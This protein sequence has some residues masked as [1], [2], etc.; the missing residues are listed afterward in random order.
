MGHSLLGQ[1][2]SKVPSTDG[3]SI[4]GRFLRRVRE[5]LSAHC[6]NAPSVT[7]RALIERAA[8]LSL[9]VARFDVMALAAGGLSDHATRQYLSYSNS[10]GRLLRQLGLQA[11]PE[12]P[13]TTAEILAQFEANK[14]VKA[15]AQS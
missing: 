3:R 12:R 14:S 2:H 13:L 15:A 9:H 8:W 10:L 1:K 11:P 5:Q 7:Q 6:G 4:D